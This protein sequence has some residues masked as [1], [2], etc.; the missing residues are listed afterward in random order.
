MHRPNKMSTSIAYGF[1]GLC[2]L[3]AVLY[4]SLLL[5]FHSPY[6]S[7]L[8]HYLLNDSWS[9]DSVALVRYPF[10]SPRGY[11]FSQCKSDTAWYVFG[12]IYARNKVHRALTIESV[13]LLEQ[14]TVLSSDYS[15]NIEVSS[16]QE[17]RWP[18]LLW[19]EPFRIRISN[20]H[21]LADADSG[22]HNQSFRFEV[23][24]SRGSVVVAPN[25]YLTLKVH[26]PWFRDHQPWSEMSHPVTPGYETFR[27]DPF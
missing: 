5:R 13:H 23:R 2:A 21:C 18:K 7:D 17:L 4:V 25:E 3:I 10:A 14:S 9:V 8:T 16:G 12:I 1:S 11:H 19:K 6:P 22:F 27:G 26:E 24:T 15:C 20:I